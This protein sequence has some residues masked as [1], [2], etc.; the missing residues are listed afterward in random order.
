[1]KGNDGQVIGTYSKLQE[2]ASA[3]TH[4]AMTPPD[5]RAT[6]HKTPRSRMKPTDSSAGITTPEQAAHIS[7][8]GDKKAPSK[9]EQTPAPDFPRRRGGNVNVLVRTALVVLI[10]AVWV[11]VLDLATTATRFAE[12]N[13]RLFG[14]AP[15]APLAE[16]CASR[17]DAG[18]VTNLADAAWAETLD[19][20]LDAAREGNAVHLDETDLKSKQKQQRS[21]Q[22]RLTSPKGV[23]LALVVETPTD[24]RPDGSAAVAARAAFR[25][26][27]VETF[28]ADAFVALSKASSDGSGTTKQAEQNARGALQRSVSLFLTKCP[29]GV[30]VVA[31]AQ[32]LTPPLLAS[33]MPAISEGGRF[34]RD[35][36]DVRADGA[37]YVFVAA[38]GEEMRAGE[39][40]REAGEAGFAKAAKTKLEKA[41]RVGNSADES[42]EPGSGVTQAFRRRIDFVVPFRK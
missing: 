11:A 18:A 20:F 38:L 30:L 21:N 14:Y 9:K 17:A 1:M 31:G 40:W 6:A 19:L 23:A 39:T 5:A 41:W 2:A 33:L 25:C 34:T 26:A 32:N 36:I 4:A 24:A 28:D 8:P 12:F 29:R 13:A 3:M 15:P 10:F 16:S 7:L 42:E 22:R 37:T 27:C 35:G